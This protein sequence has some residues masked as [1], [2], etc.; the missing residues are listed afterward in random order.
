ML[1]A[2]E[3]KA[4]TLVLGAWGCGAFGQNPY[5]MAR[6]FAVVLNKY[7]KLFDRII[8]AIKATTKERDDDMYEVFKLVLEVFYKGKVLEK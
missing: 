5:V 8:F 4:K 2:L 1:S 7:N 3:N 6:A